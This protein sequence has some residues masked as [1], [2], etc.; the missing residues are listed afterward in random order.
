M[1]VLFT[2]IKQGSHPRGNGWTA[3]RLVWLC[4]LFLLIVTPQ[5]GSQEVY[6]WIDDHGRIH[7]VDQI[8]RVPDAYRDTLKVYQVSSDVKRVHPTRKSEQVQS[9]SG[10]SQESGSAGT[11]TARSTEMDDATLAALRERM[12]QVT[13]EKTRLRVLE[14]RFR[15]KKSR[16]TVYTKRIEE[17]DEEATVIQ[18]EMGKILGSDQ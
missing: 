4:G 12:R 15:T 18:G 1:P 3:R 10:V 14:T 8:N 7:L 16:A 5:A 13:E 6:R 17:L 11:P 2:R 9:V